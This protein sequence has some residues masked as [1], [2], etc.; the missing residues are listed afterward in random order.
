[1]I[2]NNFNKSNDNSIQSDKI[3]QHYLLDINNNEYLDNLTYMINSF[4][5]TNFKKYQ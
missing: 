2:A 4:L 1:M 5:N 3:S